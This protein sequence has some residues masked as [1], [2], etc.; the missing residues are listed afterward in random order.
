MF[1]GVLLIGL[2]ALVTGCTQVPPMDFAP[3]DVLPTGHKVDLGIK[4][5]SIAFGKKEERLGNIEVGFGG[6]QY[7]SS[8]KQSF[9]DALQEALIKSAIFNDLAENRALLVAKVLELDSPEMGISFETD[10]TVRYQ[11]LSTSTGEL[12]FT[13]DIASVGSVSADYAFLGAARYTEARNVAVRENI[14]L[15]LD[16]LSEL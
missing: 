11:L 6:N 16:S 3:A 4:D 14:M 1:R 10:F 9:E 5:I 2:V 8:F 12:L 13:R 7:E 15:F